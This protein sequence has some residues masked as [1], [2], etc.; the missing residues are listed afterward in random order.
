MRLSVIVPVWNEESTLP[1]L[2][3]ELRKQCDGVDCE[4]VFVDGGSTDGTEQLLRDSGATW[5]VSDRGRGVQMNA[6]AAATGAEVLLFLHADTRLPPGWKLVVAEA[7]A[8]GHIGGFFRVRLDSPRLILRVVGH[9]IT[10]RSRATGIS[11]GDQGLFVT[12][13]I[14]ESAGGYAHLPLFEDVELTRRLRRFGR[15]AAVDSTVVTS[16]RRWDQLGPWRTIVRMW[17]LRALYALGM[18]PER[19][20][21]YYEIAR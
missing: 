16:A 15:L 20:A 1:A 14:F 9:L 11:T 3:G 10:L 19:L 6:G 21:R 5:V 8:G 13:Q 17:G 4:L 18:R 7:I 2:L 12:R